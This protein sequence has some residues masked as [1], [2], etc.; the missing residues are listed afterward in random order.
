MNHLNKI[1]RNPIIAICISPF[2]GAIFGFVAGARQN[3]VDWFAFLLLYATL[4]ITQLLDHHLFVKYNL[5][6]SRTLPQNIIYALEVALLILS[7]GFLLTQ[8]WLVTVFMVLYV[9]FIH[10][11]Y[12]P[13]N[14][15]QT[16]YHIVLTVFFNAIILNAVAFFSQAKHIDTSFMNALLPVAIVAFALN[17]A[18]AKQKEL[19]MRIRPAKWIIHSNLIVVGIATAGLLMAVYMSLPSQ[20]FFFT[21]ILLLVVVGLSFFPL[22]VDPVRAVQ[23]QNKLNYILLVYFIFALLYGISYSFK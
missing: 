1:M 19:L 12:F 4:I 11:Q 6:Q 22:V 21:Q 13:Y 18:I 20:S 15:T 17:N 3:S 9:I 10:I 16:A 5:R 8:H 7:V 2:A 14:L 23:H